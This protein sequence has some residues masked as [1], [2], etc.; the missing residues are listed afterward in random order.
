M[1]YSMSAIWMIAI[2]APGLPAAELKYAVTINGKAAGECVVRSK[3]QEGTTELHIETSGLVGRLPSLNFNCIESWK[4]GRL[5][6]LESSYTDR[7]TKG[8]TRLVGGGDGYSLKAGTKE[9]TVRGD[10]WPT[11]FLLKPADD[12]SLI[13]DIITGEV[14]RGKV[15]KVGP[16]QMEINGKLVRVAKYRLTFSG[17]ITELWYDQADRLARRK[18]DLNGQT[19]VIE[20]TGIKAD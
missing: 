1:R 20:L 12:K 2:A 17:T 7:E 16:G 5:A 15:E 11:T 8:T 3:D 4:K 19:I 14:C 10:V 18:W 9:V 13:V 6:R